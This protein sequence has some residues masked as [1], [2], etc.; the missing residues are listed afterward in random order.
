MYYMNFWAVD[1]FCS[2]E[3][4]IFGQLPPQEDKSVPDIGCDCGG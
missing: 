3:R 2:S 4:A 1:S